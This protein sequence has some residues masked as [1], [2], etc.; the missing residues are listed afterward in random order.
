MSAAVWF[1]G[2]ETHL[3]PERHKSRRGAPCSGLWSTNVIVYVEWMDLVSLRRT[4][5]P[6]AA[7]KHLVIVW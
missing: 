4:Q 5:L 7:T 2:A 6:P 1:P 3:E